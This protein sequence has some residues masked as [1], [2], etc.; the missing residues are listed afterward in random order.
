MAE[1]FK[2]TKDSIQIPYSRFLA[3]TAAGFTSLLAFAA[4]YYLPL[5]THCPI[6]LLLIAKG[7]QLGVGPEVKVFIL[8]GLFLLSTPLGFAINAFSWLMLCQIIAAIESTCFRWSASG[9]SH[10]FPA[11]Y[12][13]SAR[14]TEPL[15]AQ[16]GITDKSF[17]SGTWFLRDALETPA[18]AILNRDSQ[19][20]NL[21]LLLR[22]VAFFSLIGA[23]TALCLSL[24]TPLA[25]IIFFVSA[26]I[27]LIIMTTRWCSTTRARKTFLMVAAAADVF[28]FGWLYYTSWS[29][30]LAHQSLLFMIVA[31]CSILVAGITGYYN[32]C[33]S[34][35]HMHLAAA[36]LGCETKADSPELLNTPLGVISG[37]IARSAAP[38]RQPRTV[39]DS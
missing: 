1:G 10:F 31:L 33:A 20:R 38:G 18:L 6:R 32:C 22:N 29:D 19:V 28:G 27:V 37:L 4:A 9:R 30:S 14:Y 7:I 5:V 3:D 36:A 23:L 26:V 35:L 8:L 16:F 25:Q 11:W 12:V 13:S 2:I 17:A 15:A 39:A 21:V 34:I 24:S